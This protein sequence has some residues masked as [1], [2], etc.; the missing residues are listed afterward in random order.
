MDWPASTTDIGVVQRANR[1]KGRQITRRIAQFDKSAGLVR[2]RRERT[3]KRPYVL[4]G[5]VLNYGADGPATLGKTGSRVAVDRHGKGKQKDRWEWQF[6]AANDHDDGEPAVSV[7]FIDMSCSS[8]VSIQACFEWESP[9][10]CF[11][12]H[13]TKQRTIN[14]TFYRTISQIHP[15]GRLEEN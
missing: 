14:Q 12:P 13:G 2:E 8:N 3:A 1:Y 9:H 6:A 7:S 11:L 15:S 5:P 10:E 4:A